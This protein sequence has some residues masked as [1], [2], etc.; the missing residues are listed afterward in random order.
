MLNGVTELTDEES[1]FLKIYKEL[2]FQ[3]RKAI[4]LLMDLLIAQEQI[5]ELISLS[6]TSL[7]QFVALAAAINNPLLDE[8]FSKIKRK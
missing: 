3:S 6:Q 2:D 7:K 5:S 4:D 8:I 1:L